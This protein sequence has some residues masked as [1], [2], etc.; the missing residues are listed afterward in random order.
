MK[1]MY[2]QFPWKSHTGHIKGCELR[3]PK[4]AGKT[5]C[6]DV[7]IM[8]AATHRF[9]APFGAPTVRLTLSRIVHSLICTLAHESNSFSFVHYSSSH[10]ASNDSNAADMDGRIQ[11]LQNQKEYLSKGCMCRIS[12]RFHYGWIDN[13]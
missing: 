11:Q 8:D 4:V 9:A 10:G 7:S 13:R 2:F 6:V 12:L 3:R 5:V 1:V